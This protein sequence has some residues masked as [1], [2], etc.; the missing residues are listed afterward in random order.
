MSAARLPEPERLSPQAASVMLAFYALVGCVPLDHL[1][2]EVTG[3]PRPD[4][5]LEGR[6]APNRRAPRAAGRRERTS[7]GA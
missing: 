4:P 6:R 2:R 7:A 3:A 5:R 1:G